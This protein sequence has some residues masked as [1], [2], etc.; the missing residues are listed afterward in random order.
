MLRKLVVRSL[1]IAG[2][3]CGLSL[4]VVVTSVWLAFQP[5][6][7]YSELRDQGELTGTEED[8]LVRKQRELD[9][10]VSVARRPGATPGPPDTY[11]LRLTEKEVNSILA[12]DR[13]KRVGGLRIRILSDRIR[14]GA[15]LQVGNS[16]LVPSAELTPSVTTS[17]A[18]QFGVVGSQLGKLPL[19]TQALLKLVAQHADLSG[20]KA[21][22]EFGGDTPLIT[23]SPFGKRSLTVKSVRC[24]DGVLTTVFRPATADRIA[25]LAGEGRQS[26]P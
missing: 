21:R 20:T 10:W 4:A 26:A 22:L 24:E 6:T 2:V 13:G 18:L 11:T 7:F 14:F 12:S 8:Q 1:K 23:L 3:L 17:G 16:V 5:P 9:R 19:P 25:A 15:E